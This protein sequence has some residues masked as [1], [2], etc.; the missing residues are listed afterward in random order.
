MTLTQK[1]EVSVRAMWKGGP[2]RRWSA[3]KT[4]SHR[5]VMPR[6][7]LWVPTSEAV[8]EYTAGNGVLGTSDWPGW[9][10]FLPK[11]AR[12]LNCIWCPNWRSR[13]EQRT[14]RSVV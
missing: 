4:T 9:K 6:A 3:A 1:P 12:F 13:D 10:R 2:L 8:L 7:G 14:P 5:W 11:A